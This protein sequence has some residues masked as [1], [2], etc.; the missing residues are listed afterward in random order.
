[1]SLEMA[2][3]DRNVFGAFEKRA[4][5]LLIHD[6]LSHKIPRINLIYSLLNQSAKYATCF[7]T[8]STLKNLYPNWICVVQV[9]FSPLYFLDLVIKDFSLDAPN[10]HLAGCMTYEDGKLTVPIPGRYYIY[11]Q[12]Y[13]HDTGKIFIRVNNNFVT[14]L[15]PPYGGT[16]HH[17]ALYAGGVFKLQAGD[18]ITVMA[19]NNHG[20]V[21]GYMG[22]YHSYFGAYLI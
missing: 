19:T 11:G 20:S 8:R 15:Q 16:K 1:M 9:N 13:Y 17:G 7:F 5:V 6:T 3:R 14:M 22:P 4:P 21:R 2:Y 18:V 12:F 10:S